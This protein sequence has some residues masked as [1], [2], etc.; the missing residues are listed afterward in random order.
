MEASFR[1]NHMNIAP[2]DLLRPICSIFK[3]LDFFLKTPL[4][5]AFF[6]LFYQYF[7]LRGQLVNLVSLPRVRLLQRKRTYGKVAAS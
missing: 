1:R 5:Y 4:F 6:N 3:I 7:I 2:I